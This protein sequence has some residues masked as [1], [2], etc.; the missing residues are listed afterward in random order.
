MLLRQD[1]IE[2]SWTFF[3]P[4][5]KEFEQLCTLDQQLHDY[6]AGTWGVSLIQDT[7][8]IVIHE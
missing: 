7:V 6:P 4:V 8:Q 1:C 3:T 2:A 5:L